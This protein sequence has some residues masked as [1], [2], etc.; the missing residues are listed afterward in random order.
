MP[1]AP[2]QSGPIPVGPSMWPTMT[3]FLP[4]HYPFPGGYS[5]D[6][7]SHT[8]GD[9]HWQ[10]GLS[11]LAPQSS[12]DLTPPP[13]AFPTVEHW[14]DELENDSDFNPDGLLFSQ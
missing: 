11:Q 9:Y 12:E 7:H 5:A 4:H 6:A 13:S 14:L 1:N 8:Y 2:L 10:T 3:A